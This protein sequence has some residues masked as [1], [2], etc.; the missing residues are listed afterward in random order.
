M[1]QVWLLTAVLGLALMVPG[2]A[3][4]KKTSSGKSSSKTSKSVKPICPVTGEEAGTRYSSKW[5][6]GKV[7]FAAS[8]AKTQFGKT[9]DDF[10]QAANHQLVMT[11]QYAQH[12]CPMCSKAIRRS[13]Q[14]SLRRVGV[15]FSSDECR[16][17][18]ID[19]STDKKM[20]LAFSDKAF[21]EFFSTPEDAAKVLAKA[22]EKP[23]KTSSKKKSSSKSSSG[24]KK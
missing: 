18:F 15:Y 7:Y 23:Q 8:A 14:S 10:A 3:D 21:E 22:A 17:K 20:S 12:S 11:R 24:K 13:H 6:D 4:S 1:K 2:V 5:H 19:Q 9:P 16:R